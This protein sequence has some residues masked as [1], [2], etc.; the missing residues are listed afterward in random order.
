MIFEQF[1]TS[2]VDITDH[3]YRVEWQ[4]GGSLHIHG[5]AWVNNAPDQS[6]CPE[7][8]LSQ[9]WDKYVSS[10][11][12]ASMVVVSFIYS[13]YFFLYSLYTLDRRSL[14]QVLS[15]FF[16]FDRRGP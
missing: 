10:W 5:L 12:T 2:Y 11:N 7:I 15:L 13:I 8:D 6:L 16:P 14:A 9:F 1:L 3:W 4:H